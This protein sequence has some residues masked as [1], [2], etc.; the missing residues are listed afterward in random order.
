MFYTPKAGR[1]HWA[2]AAKTMVCVACLNRAKSPYCHRCHKKFE[3]S[4]GTPG[5]AL[6]ERCNKW[7]CGE[8][9]CLARHSSTELNTWPRQNPLC[10]NC[11]ETDEAEGGEV[12]YCYYYCY[13][14]YY[15]Y[16]YYYFY[17]YFYYY[18]YYYY[19]SKVDYTPSMYVLCV[20]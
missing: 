16:Y 15:Y 2:S 18:Y 11:V 19:C 7:V 6:C 3:Y 5:S 17:F 13:C 4:L 8:T 20:I 14:Y 1:H 9:G 10:N 12:A